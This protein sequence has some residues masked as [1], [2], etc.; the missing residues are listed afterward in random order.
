M[1]INPVEIAS[2]PLPVIANRLRLLFESAFA[3][4]YAWNIPLSN[5]SQVNALKRTVESQ[6]YQYRFFSHPL[7]KDVLCVLTRLKPGL[8]FKVWGK[9]R[10]VAV[11]RATGLAAFHEHYRK[12]A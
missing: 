8:H 11:L 4:E 7:S 2:A 6:G 10:E 3:F 12:A 9:N 5:V 1:K